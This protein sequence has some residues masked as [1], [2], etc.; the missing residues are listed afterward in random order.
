MHLTAKPEEYVHFKE[1]AWN[2][3]RMSLPRS[4]QPAAID[5]F[6]LIF[7][8]DD[9]P[10]L[11]IRWSRSGY[12]ANARE[13]IYRRLHRTAKMHNAELREKPVHAK[14]Q[15]ALKPHH[16]KGF[17]WQTG[18]HSADGIVINCPLCGM[19]TL[20]QFYHGCA[21]RNQQLF[22]RILATFKDHENKRTMTYWAMYDIRA[23]LPHDYELIKARFG[24]GFFQLDFKHKATSVSL[25]RFAPATA[26]L[27]DISLLD[28]SRKRWPAYHPQFSA[29]D[30]AGLSRI[31]YRTLLEEKLNKRVIG[32][33]FGRKR[34]AWVRVWLLKRP[35]RIF[36]VRIE[37]NRQHTQPMLTTLAANFSHV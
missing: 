14:W 26:I 7:E 28:F 4:W 1:V 21:K 31:E 30:V 32:R 3:I 22:E 29:E 15:N 19:V 25:Y 9:G 34:D 11:E 16:L 24:A 13:K 37:G 8:D 12:G 36:A 5:L 35:N 27:S 20:L 6:H 17:R 10:A 2:G 18:T 33:L 23:E